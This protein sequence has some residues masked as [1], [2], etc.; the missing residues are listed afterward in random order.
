MSVLP[1]AHAGARLCYLTT[2]GRVS[3]NPHEVEIW[4][5]ADGDT[6][7]ILSGGGDR[8]DWV[9]NIRRNPA[10]SIRIGDAV[11]HGAGLLIAQDEPLD[12]HARQVVARKY[13]EVTRDGELS[14]WA[15]TSLVVA[16]NL[17]GAGG[18]AS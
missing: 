2:T 5:A 17:S 13:G 16:I 7:F 10:C 1:E 12:A 8:S 9:R 3:S 4:F 18:S 14:E 11:Y 15:R 6:A